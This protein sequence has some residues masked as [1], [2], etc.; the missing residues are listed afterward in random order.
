GLGDEHAGI[1][2]LPADAP[3]GENFAHYAGYDDPV[4]EINLTPNR[5]DCAGVLGIA[6][7]L[8][9]T[10]IGKLKPLVIKPV[11]GKERSRIK[12]VLD[13]AKGDKACPLFVGRL[14]RNIRNGP[15]P[16][17]LQER[18]RAIGLRP[19]SALVDITNYLTFDCARP[20]HVFDAKKIKGNLWV[21]PAKGG[22][23]LAALNGKVY[24]V[25]KGM[26]AI[27]DDS[28]VLSLAGIMGGESSACDE[29]TTDVFIESAL[30]D[31][32]R[33]ARTGRALQIGSDARYR[34]ERGV[35][36]VFT[37]PG[38][39]L[40]TQLVL[41]LCGTRDS[42]A[43]KLEI[44]GAVP[45]TAR[46]IVLDAKKCARHVG[47][48]VPAAEQEKILSKLGFAVKRKGKA[49]AVMP[50]SWRPDV[51]G[52]EDL[53]E[54][55]ARIKGYDHIP[56]TTLQN[57]HPVTVSAIDVMD[58]RVGMARRALA[59]QGLMEAVTWSF[60][61]SAIAAHFGGGDAGLKLLNP[62]SSDLDVMRPSILGN[63]VMAAKRNADRGFADAG[64]FEVGPVY[65]NAAPE[66]QETVAACLR[67]GMT[68]RNW[69]APARAV[70][71][72]DA[73]ADAIA[74]L[75]AAGAP[76]AALQVTADAPGYYH[77]GRS[78]CV[79]LGP[80]LLASFG[81]IHPAVLLA[82]DAS[83]P[84]AG[85]EIFLAA[86]P[87]SRAAGNARPLLKLEPLQ[88]V[89]RDFAF[90]VESGV[91]AAKLIKAIRDAGKDL[92]RDVTVFDVYEGDRI[93]AGKKSVA[94]GVTLQPAEHTLTDAEIEAL[95]TRIADSAK[96]AVGAVL[97]A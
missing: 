74:A 45:G 61:P 88:P 73:K 30:F 77:P 6:R 55:I 35:D 12:V 79:R 97:R 56:A 58:R 1:I 48:E 57:P 86:I 67:A 33:T 36:P 5:S 42:V 22:E 25:E 82:C 69:L 44:A 10:G 32:G 91:T 94:L 90:V 80:A 11:N 78:G 47:V 41:D 14:V 4:I 70:D 2:A 38:A 96:K 52:A 46:V 51:E 50:P 81:E 3:V 29:N 85:C 65:K 15:S 92:I 59:A 8:A 24:E 16:A 87:Q 53:V 89:V 66:G 20:L 31:P 72:Y 68:P 64:L 7:D 28:G 83:A 49:F 27:G 13:F 19:I 17:W 34:F 21:R 40:A 43:A 9:A 62:I 23:K 39:E 63:L 75:A 26:T 71:A 54:E 18:L 76:V 95:A 93:E 37:I 84:M 60:M